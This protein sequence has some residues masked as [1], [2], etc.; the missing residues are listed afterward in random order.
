[1]QSNAQTPGK[2]DRENGVIGRRIKNGSVE[3]V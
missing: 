1:M 2:V 3:T